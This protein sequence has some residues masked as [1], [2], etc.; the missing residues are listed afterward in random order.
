MESC[1][2]WHAKNGRMKSA[3]NHLF[4]KF[5]DFFTNSYQGNFVR[6]PNPLMV[7]D[8]D[9]V[10]IALLKTTSLRTFVA[11]KSHRSTEGVFLQFLKVCLQ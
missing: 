3:N 10:Y 5:H 2:V 9:V 6:G 7:K 11:N 1:H 8:T 4:T